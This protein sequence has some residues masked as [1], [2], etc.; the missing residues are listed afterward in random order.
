VRLLSSMLVLA[1]ACPADD[2]GSTSTASRGDGTTAG[3]D[4]TTVGSS[5]GAS[6]SDEGASPGA[7][8]ADSECRLHSDCC[9][10]QALPRDAETPAC[11]AQCDRPMCEQWGVSE[12]LCSHTCLLRLV[13]CDPALVMCDEAAPTCEQGFAPSIE[14]RCWT[15]HCVPVELCTP[16]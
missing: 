8:S 13:D 5:G 10:C 2:H 9:S 1:L 4:E 6:S 3:G 12:V 15:R 16:F 14:S 7:C 11:D